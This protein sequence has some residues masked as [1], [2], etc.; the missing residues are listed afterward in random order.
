MKRFTSLLLAVVLVLAFASTA[1]AAPPEPGS[2]STNFTVQN[3]DAAESASV[4]ADYVNQAG[5][6]DANKTKSIGSLASDGFPASDSGLL[7][8]WLGSVVVSADKEIVAFAQM[9]WS[10]GSSADGKTA[11]AYNGFTVGADTLYLP[12]LAARDAQFSRISV[13][14]AAT[15]S[16][17]EQVDYTVKF[18]DRSGNLS[19]TITDSIYLGA[20]ATY[21][22]SKP[23]TGKNPTLAAEWLGS[24]VVEAA[25]DGTPLAAVATMH[26]RNYA[27]G[28]SA[29]TGGG[30]KVYLPSATRRIPDGTNWLQFTGV[31]VQ[32][33]DVATA[34]EVTVYW[35]DRAGT[36]LLSFTDNIPANSAH[37]YNSRYPDTSDIPTAAAASFAGDIGDNWN[38]SVVISS[39]NGTNV[40]A[41]SNLQWTASHPS[42]SAASAYTSDA[43]GFATVYAPATF[44]RVNGASWTQFT[45]LIVQNIGDSACDDF[46]VSWVAR[47]ATSPA[48]TFTDS[49]APNISHGYNTKQGS[50]GSDI[51]ASADVTDLTDDYRGAVTISA[52]GC[53][54]IAIHNTSWPVWTDNTTYNSFGK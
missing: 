33:L 11:G 23:G 29:V 10:A 2:G 24:A 14:S 49:L 28:Y 31:I 40:V 1:M 9:I 36:E 22:L 54:L 39:T 50:A 16:A 46:T 15:P 8:G 19:A 25:V 41:V 47:G 38:G 34:A 6:I 12:S 7:D 42:G 35:Y 27:A 17:T 3:L 51:P 20:Q 48:L 18:Y 53:E 43:S 5:A 32:N 37:G 4:R 13:Q 52:P 44:R 30:T 26:W 21:D 45:G